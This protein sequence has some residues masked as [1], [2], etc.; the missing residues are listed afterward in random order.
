[1]EFDTLVESGSLDYVRG[2][3]ISNESPEYISISISTREIARDNLMSAGYVE[4]EVCSGLRLYTTHEYS[5]PVVVF[6]PQ[7]SF[8]IV[9]GGLSEREL[10]WFASQWCEPKEG[11]L[12]D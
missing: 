1:L 11:Q 3:T 4:S 9:T 8:Q 12:S 5:Y 2:S 10:F 7:P 6:K